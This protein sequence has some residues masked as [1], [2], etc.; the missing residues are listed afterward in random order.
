MEER[1]KLN[2]QMNEGDYGD[3]A[4]DFN[5][6][7]DECPYLKFY[8]GK[9]SLLVSFTVIIVLMAITLLFFVVK[10]CRQKQA[11]EELESGAIGELNDKHSKCR[12]NDYWPLREGRGDKNGLVFC[13]DDYLR[14]LGADKISYDFEDEL[15]FPTSECRTCANL[16]FTYSEQKILLHTTYIGGYGVVSVLTVVDMRNGIAMITVPDDQF[17]GI[18]MNYS[19]PFWIEESTYDQMRHLIKGINLEKT[20]DEIFPAMKVSY[21]RIDTETNEVECYDE[22]GNLVED[23]APEMFEVLPEGLTL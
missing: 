6:D 16:S 2:E 13:F 20:L 12:E 23:D 18:V 8:E 7:C 15:D 10:V 19:N 21:M 22:N 14:D 11:I 4:D 3:F 1:R 9:R 17:D 5:D